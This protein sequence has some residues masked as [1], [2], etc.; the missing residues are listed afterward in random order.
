LA[1]GLEDTED[2]I[3][4]LEQALRKVEIVETPVMERVHVQTE[5]TIRP[6]VVDNE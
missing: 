2:L 5:G 3:G 4:D 1:V 6:T